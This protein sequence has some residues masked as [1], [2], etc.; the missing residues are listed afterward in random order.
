M[1]IYVDTNVY[2]DLFENRRSGLRELGLLAGQVFDDILKKRFR[3]VTSD[4]VLAELDKH[5]HKNKYL[6]LMTVL[7][8]SNIVC[9]STTSQDKDDARKLSASNYPDALHVILAKKVNAKIL[10]TQ[11]IEDFVEFQK[12]IEVISPEFLEMYL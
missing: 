10:V 8:N 12:L 5:G 9:V 11:N 6:E 1:D 2:M 4:W 7:G 3:L